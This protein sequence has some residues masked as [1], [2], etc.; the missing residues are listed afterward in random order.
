VEPVVGEAPWV[1]GEPAVDAPGAGNAAALDGA[2]DDEL[3]AG[4]ASVVVLVVMI[5]EG[6]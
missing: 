2:G 1:T 3:D 6:S 5:T 4:E